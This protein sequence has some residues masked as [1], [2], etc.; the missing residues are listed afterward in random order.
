MT[1][2]CPHHAPR[3]S[4]RLLARTRPMPP[5][6]TTTA[7]RR[8]RG[9]QAQPV[10]RQLR[11]LL[12]RQEDPAREHGAAQ[13]P[14]RRRAGA[15]A[16]APQRCAAQCNPTLR[17][18]STRTDAR[19]KRSASRRDPQA[20]LRSA[21]QRAPTPAAL[22]STLTH[23][24]SKTRRNATLVCLHPTPLCRPSSLSRCAALRLQGGGRCRGAAAGPIPRGD[25]VLPLRAGASAPTRATRFACLCASL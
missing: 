22:P 18:A 8:R 12:R 4:S 17:R 23:A 15:R 7:G 24:R 10:W 19:P 13:A 11:L 14:P 25:A 2:T 20:A 9:R 6:H 1:Q 21:A 5:R 3:V 16:N